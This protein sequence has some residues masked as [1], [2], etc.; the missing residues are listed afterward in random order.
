MY[1]IPFVSKFIFIIVWVV[2]IYILF[3]YITTSKK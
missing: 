1:L 2:I 3:D